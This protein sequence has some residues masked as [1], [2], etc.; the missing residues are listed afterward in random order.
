MI[1]GIDLGTSNSSVAVHD[2]V[3]ALLVEPERESKVLPSAVYLNGTDDILA[4]T[5]AIVAGRQ[6]PHRLFRYFKRLIGREWDP[7]Q[8]LGYQACQ[9]PDGMTWMRGESNEIYS[10]V[11]LSAHVVAALEDAVKRQYQYDVTGAVICVPAGFNQLQRDATKAAGEAAGIPNVMVLEEPIAAAF[12]YGAMHSKFRTIAVVDWGA[13][14]FDCTILEARKSLIQPRAKDGDPDL[15]GRDMDF[16]IAREIARR[17]IEMGHGDLAT[18]DAA[19]ERVL[20]AAEEAKIDLSSRSQARIELMDIE[21]PHH[22]DMTITVE[23]LNEIAKPLIRRVVR[24]CENLLTRSGY[25]PEDIDDVVLVGGMT[26]MPA[27]RAAITDLFKRK[28]R[29]DFDPK[30]VVALGAATYGA[31]TEG[32]VRTVV[33]HI[34]PHTLTLETVPVHMTP[35][36]GPAQPPS[37]SLPMVLVPKDED[38]G[39]DGE[40]KR[41]TIK[42]AREDQQYV[43]VNL[44]QGDGIRYPDEDRGSHVLVR[45]HVLRAPE[46]GTG[47]T[48]EMGYDALGEIVFRA[49]GATEMEII[50][51]EA[52]PA[53]QPEPDPPEPEGASDL[54]ELLSEEFP[55]ETEPDN[56]ER[57]A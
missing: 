28:P 52:P 40:V 26:Y 22:L 46:S 43:S 17:W 55:T 47:V 45:Q 21:P 41:I 19:W 2:G 7:A 16:A 30:T 20:N 31:I 44:W 12:A 39:P 23:E 36:Q 53:P 56:L 4:G 54:E 14:T 48:V 15:G 38:L 24:I 49:L 33:H 32:R 10:P 29:H 11:E 18:R 13:G 35:V 5:D 51:D 9:G 1:I 34:A 57:A 25:A 8:A 3:R 37:S 42:P 6:F 50:R 27:L